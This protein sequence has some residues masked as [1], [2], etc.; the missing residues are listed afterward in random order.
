MRE[1]G[2]SNLAVDSLSCLPL[3]PIVLLLVFCVSTCGPGVDNDR[4][5]QSPDIVLL[6]R[7]ILNRLHS[8]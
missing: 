7:T 5:V 1:L 6:S 3:A 8:V 4:L 2:Q